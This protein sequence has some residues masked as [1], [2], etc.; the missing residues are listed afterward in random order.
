MKVDGLDRAVGRGGVKLVAERGG[1][2]LGEADGG[3][4]V[5]AQ[6]GAVGAA[7]AAD[8]LE[9]RFPA[10]D[11]V[12]RARD[13]L[14]GE[15]VREPADVAGDLVL[16]PLARLVQ[17]ARGDKRERPRGVVVEVGALVGLEARVARAHDLA[18]AVDKPRALLLDGREPVAQLPV[19][20]RREG[21]GIL[22]LL[23]AVAHLGREGVEEARVDG[24]VAGLVQ[25]RP[26]GKGEDLGARAARAADLR[27]VALRTRQTHTHMHSALGSKRGGGRCL[28]VRI[29][30]RT[31]LDMHASVTLP[32]KV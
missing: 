8:A 17:K 2:E 16:E 4:E 28:L 31:P 7:A 29:S 12:A 23:A 3:V 15:V 13:N 27:V 24:V 26:R 9:L 10:L 30:K 25:R 1:A 22:R 21:Q 6:V 19:V 14:V 32:E 11:L 18:H 5:V 20:G